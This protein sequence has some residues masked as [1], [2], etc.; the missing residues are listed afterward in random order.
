MRLPALLAVSLLACTAG[1]RLTYVPLTGPDER[2]RYDTRGGTGNGGDNDQ[3]APFADLDPIRSPQSAGAF[4]TLTFRVRDDD[5][6]ADLNVSLM[7]EQDEISRV[8]L[9]SSAGDASIQLPTTVGDGWYIRLRVSDRLGFQ[10]VV[11]SN[12]FELAPDTQAPPAPMVTWI[13]QSPTAQR[14]VHFVVTQCEANTQIQL[15]DTVIGALSAWRPC[16]TIVIEAP[17]TQDGTY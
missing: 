1:Q 4:L 3:S 15:A 6:L 11:D 14:S 12:T 5:G 7:H 2:T 10:T 13:T 9:P 17:F 8:E 16:E